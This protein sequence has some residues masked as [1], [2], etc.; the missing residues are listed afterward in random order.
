MFFPKLWEAIRNSPLGDYIAESPWAFPTFET[1]H[2]FAVVTVFGT[3]AVMDMRMI[4]LA[5]TGRPITA[6]SNDTL[7]ITWIAFVVAAITGVLLFTSK[8]DYY[9]VN[10]WF[11]S[12]MCL[13]A[14]AG[15]NMAVFHSTVW[16]KVS[17]FDTARIIPSK[18][19]LAGIISLTLWIIV[20]ICGRMIGFT[21]D[22]YLPS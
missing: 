12:K 16:K 5:S 9:M 21:L 6:V 1:F 2:V 19:K 22:K 4:G 13:I 3:I 14:I 11:I 15:I 8:A 10:P 20:I 7:R 17:E 18:V